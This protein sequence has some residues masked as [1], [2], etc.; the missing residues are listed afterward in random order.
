M[1]R[2]GYW[3]CVGLVLSIPFS[4]ALIEIF[5][6]LLLMAWLVLRA[7]RG[8]AGIPS[9]L[10]FGWLAVFALWNFASIFVGPFPH[11]GL[12][13]FLK[14]LQYGGV[15]LAAAE[16]TS[17]LGK[18][19][20]FAVACLLA[21][22]LVSLDALWQLGFGFD[23][24]R[25]RA[26]LLT[27]EGLRLTGPFSFSNGLGAYMVFLLPVALGVGASKTLAFRER[28]LGALLAVLFS[29]VLART[30]SRGAWLGAAGALIFLAVFASRKLW[31]ALLALCGAA[32]LAAPWNVWF[33]L[34]EVAR[35]EDWGIQFRFQEWG[36]AL[37]IV[38]NSPWLGLGVNTYSAHGHIYPH[39]SYLQMAAEIGLPGLILFVG[40]M[41]LVFQKA[42][43]AA[44]ARKLASGDLLAWAFLAGLVGL[45]AHSFF[46]SILYSLPLAA[47]FWVSAGVA[48]GFKE[49]VHAASD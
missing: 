7:R 39:N 15:A 37:K 38:R 48:A 45:M 14:V 18:Q 5:S 6:F 24:A 10:L 30:L 47:L 27:E 19:K 11:L 40:W 23:L 34:K 22:L 32:F 17:E 13:G 43:P 20:A 36:Q 44:R 12:R 16:V 42:I 28:F 4:K 25:H 41:A 46:D 26:L 9:K 8:A 2:L 3:A 31:P 33:R 49:V 29:V 21:G 35:V 1:V